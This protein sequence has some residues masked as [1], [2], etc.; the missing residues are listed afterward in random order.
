MLT[1]ANQLYW[2]R[3]LLRSHLQAIGLTAGDAVMVHAALRS[4]GLMINGPDTL[5]EAILD[6]VGPDG[7][8]LSYVG[9]NPLYEDAADSHG[10]VPEELKAD[11]PPFDPERSRASRDH[12]AFAE[13]VRTTPGA[14]RSGNSGASFA[15]IGGKAAWFTANHPLQYGYGAES[16]FARLV[17]TKGKVLMI[18]APFDTMSILHHA[19]HLAQIPGKR[20]RRIEVPL[21]INDKT[22]WRMVEEF[23]TTDPVVEGLDENYFATIVEEFLAKGHGTAGKIG[24]AFSILVPATD[25]VA[26]AV[27]W[28]EQRFPQM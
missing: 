22:E 11:I 1:L 25:I 9:W 3:Q 23:D 2:T 15:A 21:L 16:P 26:F 19:E 14:L 17:E 5:I 13:F 18:G 10:R 20:V 12:G 27:Q 6:V 28:L 24:S 8:L 4:A 7:T